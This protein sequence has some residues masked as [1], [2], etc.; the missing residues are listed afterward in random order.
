M[1]GVAGDRLHRRRKPSQDIA[2]DLRMAFEIEYKFK[3]PLAIGD[4][5]FEL[6]Q[7]LGRK[8]GKQRRA[9][10]NDRAALC[11]RAFGG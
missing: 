9:Q 10:A 8:R 5:F 11:G 4:G 7:L 1:R 6:R 2:S 3:Y